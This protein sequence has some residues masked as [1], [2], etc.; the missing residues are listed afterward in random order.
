MISKRKF[1]HQE[2]YEKIKVMSNLMRFTILDLTKS[3]QL[4]ISELSSELSL[5]Y[6]KCADYVKILE[7]LNL[8]SKTRVGKEVRVKSNVDFLTNKIIFLTNN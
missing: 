5:S 6:T 2:L 3:K 8:V 7:N 4:S 1:E